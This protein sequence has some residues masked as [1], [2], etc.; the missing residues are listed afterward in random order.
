M[1]P[2]RRYAAN[3]T[4]IEKN[5]NRG[6]IECLSGEIAC[7]GAMDSHDMVRLC[8][9]ELIQPVV[10]DEYKQLQFEILLNEALSIADI[11]GYKPTC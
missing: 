1:G 10:P 2:F 6:G 4:S 11:P 7:T 5:L 3:I 9:A 8:Q